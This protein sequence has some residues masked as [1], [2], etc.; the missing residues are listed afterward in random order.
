M[1]ERRFEVRDFLRLHPYWR[2]NESA[3]D[4]LASFAIHLLTFVN[5]RK[6][7]YGHAA[8]KM[9][10]ARNSAQGSPAFAVLRPRIDDNNLL[11]V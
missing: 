11:K 5:H 1:V 6:D 8:G 10:F 3:P 2:E 9:G 4:L 7:G